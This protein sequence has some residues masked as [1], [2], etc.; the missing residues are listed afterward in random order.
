[1]T[2][3]KTYIVFFKINSKKPN[4]LFLVHD[5]TATAAK[6]FTKIHPQLPE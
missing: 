5:A 2:R 6:S 1:M 3:R 4:Q